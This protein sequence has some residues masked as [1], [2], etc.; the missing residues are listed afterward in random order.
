MRKQTKH[1]AKESTQTL[2]EE[3]KRRRKGTEKIFE[4]TIAEN[5]LS[6][7]RKQTSIP[8]PR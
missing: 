5:F 2:R 1:Y 3:R 8:T 6:W 7:V 4:D